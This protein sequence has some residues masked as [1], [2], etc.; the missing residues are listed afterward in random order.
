VNQPPPSWVG[1]S[2]AESAKPISTALAW[3]VNSTM[4]MP[5]WWLPPTTT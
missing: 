4:L 1:V 2:G 5:D 3:S